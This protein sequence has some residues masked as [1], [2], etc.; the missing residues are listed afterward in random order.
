MDDQG[1]SISP[2]FVFAMLRKL[3]I[4]NL[5]I[6]SDAS[7]APS[8]GVNLI[9]GDNGSGKT[10]LLEAVHLLAKGRSF[11][12][13]EMS[14]LLRDGQTELHLFTEFD[15]GMG[16]KH[17]LGMQRN[18]GQWVVRLDG[19]QARKRSEILAMLPIQW[20]GADPQSLVTG[21]PELRRAFLDNGV[22][23]VEPR[24]LEV[25][26]SYNRALEQRNAA[27]RMK[28]QILDGWDKQLA[29]FATQL[30]LFR[31]D[32][33][34]G[35]IERVHGIVRSWGFQWNLVIRYNRGWPE[36]AALL[37]VFRDSLAVDRKRGFTG[38][39]PQRGDLLIRTGGIRSGK[40]LS[41]GQLKML[42]SALHLGQS[43][44]QK[45]KGY[46]PGI[47]LFDDL[48]A[49]LDM[50]NR[51]RLLESICSIFE[52]AFLVALAANE[53]SE[54]RQV[55]KVFHVEHGLFKTA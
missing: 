53:V 15:D 30:D 9:V 40:K 12:H 24:Y 47:L 41:Q 34:D 11:R 21:M 27:L 26:Q 52:Q 10:T 1:L 45:E 2:F 43:L 14:P 6:I 42:A 55:S 8:G 31:R 20:I 3:I 29:H 17:R 46:F 39:G 37:N 23:H 36:D 38:F 50:A 4:H 33:V 44:L 19:Q 54:C 28:G 22:F 51:D 32:Y 49:E 7:L 35:L 25:L 48:P 16:G 5:R 13:R 18:E